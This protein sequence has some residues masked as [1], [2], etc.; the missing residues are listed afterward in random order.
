LAGLT[1]TGA[2]DITWHDLVGIPLTAGLASTIV[3]GCGFEKLPTSLPVRAQVRYT[4]APVLTFQ[5]PSASGLLRMSN[6]SLVLSAEIAPT[7]WA[8]I[9][10]FGGSA[11]TPV[12]ISIDPQLGALTTSLGTPVIQVTRVGFLPGFNGAGSIPGVTGIINAVVPLITAS[13]SQIPLPSA[14]LGGGNLTEIS[15]NPGSADNLS[16]YLGP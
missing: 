8:P 6:L 4:V 3:P 9:A 5:P 10:R 16:I 15:M 14:G 13:F 11:T 2:L 7:I 1:A 12:T